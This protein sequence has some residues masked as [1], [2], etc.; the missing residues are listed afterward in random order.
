MK[1]AIIDYG[2][3]NTGSVANALSYLKKEPVIT[4]NRGEIE[5][6]SHIILPGV[7]AF[8]D[9]MQRLQE[10]GLIDILEKEVLEKKKPYLGICLG[11]QFLAEVGTEGGEHKGLGWVKGRVRRFKVD[12]KQFPVPHIGWN[13]LLRGGRVWDGTL[14]ADTPQGTAFY[15]VHSFA[16]KP[17]NPEHV[18]ATCDYDGHKTVAAVVHDNMVGVQ[19]H[20]EVMHTVNGQKILENFAFG[21]CKAEKAITAENRFIRCWLKRYFTILSTIR[22]NCRVHFSIVIHY[23]IILLYIYLTRNLFI[24][25]FTYPYIIHLY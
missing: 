19:F 8:G 6:A 13:G 18:L 20:P 14:L 4:K 7:G 15:F 5:Q 22:T 9:G 11:M 3:G 12:E 24:Y 23:I 17:E 2:M 21:I 10:F 25:Y 1:V 16:A